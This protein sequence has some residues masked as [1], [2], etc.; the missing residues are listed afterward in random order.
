M[1]AVLAEHAL[2]ALA[3]V[4]AGLINAIAGGGTLITFP[5]LVALGVPVVSANVTNT[6][7]L[8][9]GYFGGTFA[10][11][12][13]LGVQRR[14]LPFIIVPAALGGVI[15][16][17]LLVASSDELFEALVPFLLLAACLLLATGDRIKAALPAARRAAARGA[18][19]SSVI[20][21]P[22]TPPST[23]T[24]T[25]IPP[26]Q[27]TPMH[28]E[29]AGPPAAPATTA[30]PAAA[31]LPPT[32]VA[33]AEHAPVPALAMAVTVL[34]IGIYAGYFGAGMGIIALAV[35]GLTLNDTMVRINALKQLVAFTANLVAAGLFVFSG[36][37]DFSY[38][39]VMAPA[40]LLGG[41]VGGRLVQRL[42]P[43]VLRAVV[44]AVG[45]A[46]AVNF[47]VR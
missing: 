33:P 38:V 42:N 21:V 6:V 20:P 44:I 34:M 46:V 32:R 25:T 22:A 14:R 41:S 40:S 19:A 23:G 13:D 39:A 37:V 4:A 43:W 17:L 45:V 11:R 8:C 9:P 31:A 18:T 36:K 2:A 3:A 24:A 5:A 1:D 10:Q 26:R 27:S 30:E 47:W 28:R 7:A 29:R 12:K 15:G 16:S 35:L